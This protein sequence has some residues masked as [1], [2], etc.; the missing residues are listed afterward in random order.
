MRD[1]KHME[2][3]SRLIENAFTT[4]PQLGIS[5]EIVVQKNGFG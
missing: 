3:E 5:H 1:P 4:S 2:L